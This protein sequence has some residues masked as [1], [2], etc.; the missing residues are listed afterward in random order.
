MSPNLAGL[1]VIEP[2]CLALLVRPFDE[3]FRHKHS[4]SNDD[5]VVGQIAHEK[6]VGKN[7]ASLLR[8]TERISCPSERVEHLAEV[9][10]PENTL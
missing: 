5:Q 10:Q 2:C 3:F 4:D 6:P 1:T 8:L 9:G 7:R